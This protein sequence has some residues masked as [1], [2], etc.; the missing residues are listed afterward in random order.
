MHLAVP[1]TGHREPGGCCGVAFL[2]RELLLQVRVRDLGGEGLQDAL[3]QDP[4]LPR[5]QMGGFADQ[6]LH[7]LRGKHRVQVVGEVLHRPDDHVRLLDQHVPGRETDPD[8]C[9]QVGVEGLGEM[10]QPGGDGPVLPGHV[11]PPVRRTGRGDV[12]T[13][14][15]RV[16]M[17][18]DP[19]LQLRQPSLDPGQRVSVSP[20]SS[21]DI[22]HNATSA[23]SSSTAPTPATARDTG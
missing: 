1:V 7:G 18:S 13:D 4:Q 10:H 12:V 11:C 20:A 8:R 15:H 22:D 6:H 2:L 23:T 3:A 9:E 16:G 17:C 21:A 14:V 5:R 19:E